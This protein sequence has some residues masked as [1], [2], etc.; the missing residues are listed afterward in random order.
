MRDRPP[1]AE[2]ELLQR[3][4]LSSRWTAFPAATGP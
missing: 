1:I 3:Q 4:L 2:P